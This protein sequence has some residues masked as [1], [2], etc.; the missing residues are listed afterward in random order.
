MRM[1]SL[2]VSDLG[3]T[4]YVL[5]TADMFICSV[6]YEER[7]AVIPSEV[8]AVLRSKAA[9]LAFKETGDAALRAANEQKLW[10]LGMKGRIPLSADSDREVL[11]LLND[12][13]G[14]LQ[15]VHLVVDYSSMSRVWYNAMINW[16]WY[17]ARTEGSVTIDFLYSG[18]IYGVADGPLVIESVDVLPGIE[19]LTRP[20]DPRLLCVGLGFDASAIRSFYEEFQPEQLVCYVGTELKPSVYRS[21][22]RRDNREI[23]SMAAA[24][25]DIPIW[26][27]E[28][29]YRTL[30]AVLAP[31]ARSWDVT[32]L[33][34]GTKPHT[35][36]SLLLCHR[37]QDLRCLRVKR[38]P[39]VERIAASFTRV[40]TRVRFAYRGVEAAQSGRASI[41]SA[42]DSRLTHA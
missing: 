21:R 26:S 27:V 38:R 3:I 39:R 20:G 24:V 9:V 22:V 8:P 14:K 36:T 41:H 19:G 28:E 13:V 7:C 1:P 4:N 12:R 6:G 5:S 32:I 42:P 25:V 35:L 23:L 11:D 10:D 15:D 33:P 34:L 40:R 31:Q 29:S 30:G 18:G 17:R 2:F 16:A 37:F